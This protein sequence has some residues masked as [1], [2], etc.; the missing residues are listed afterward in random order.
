MDKRFLAILAGIAVIFIGIAVISQSGKDDKSGDSGNAQPTSH[1]IGEGKKKVTLIEY[2]DFQC[3]VCQAY[4]Q[5]IKEV[6]EKYSADIFFQFRHL[7]LVSIHPNAF[8]AARAA[9]AAGI[10]GKFWEMHSMLYEPTNWQA[11]TTSTNA[12]A[13]FD[14]YAKQLGLDEAK[15][16][17]DYASDTANDAINA[18]LAEFDKTGRP[19][20]TP[21]FFINGRPI[22][23]SE[24]SDG[25]VPSVEKISALIEAEIAKQ[26]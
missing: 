3:P 19:S 25:N 6:A 7:P 12:R 16:K 23:N 24:L 26:N 13:L 21:S 20:A 11:W 9:E 10:Q 2:G 8:A 17:T 15:F 14:A 22:E 4:D 1:I 5:P 18:D